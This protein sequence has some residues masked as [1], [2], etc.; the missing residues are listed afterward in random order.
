[1]ETSTLRIGTQNLTFLGEW[2]LNPVDGG[3]FKPLT[4]LWSRCAGVGAPKGRRQG[5]PC[6]GWGRRVTC[7]RQPLPNPGHCWEG[8]VWR[9]VFFCLFVCFKLE[10]LCLAGA[11]GL[12]VTWQTGGRAENCCEQP[13]Q[14]ALHRTVDLSLPKAGLCLVGGLPIWYHSH[15]G[16]WDKVAWGGSGTVGALSPIHTKDPTKI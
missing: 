3:H 8:E 11:L 2:G 13:G 14:L 1:M 10:K 9:L 4:V 12:F 16:Q 6:P 15:S 7:L 5:R